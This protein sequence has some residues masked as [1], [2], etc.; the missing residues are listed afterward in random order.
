[1]TSISRLPRNKLNRIK[2]EL[3]LAHEYC[4]FLHDECARLLVEYEAADAERITITFR[5]EAEANRFNE[6]AKKDAIT[7]LRGTG[8][9]AEARRVILNRITMAMTSDLLHH[10]Y[11]AL[12]CLE[13]RKFVV[14]LNL[15][16]KPLMDSL[17]Y[18]SWMLGDEDAFYAAFERGEPEALALKK[19]GNHRAKIIEDAL[20]QTGVAEILDAEYIRRAIFDRKFAEGLHGLFQHAVHLITVDYPELKSSP[21]NF[22]FIFKSHTDE[23]IY[24]GVYE[25]LP[26][27]MLYL[28]HVVLELFDR[29][30][31]ME[32]AGKR[33]FYVRSSTALH[34]IG[35]RAQARD[36]V[37]EL[38][39]PFKNRLH[40]E[41]C[42]SAYRGTIHN[43]ARM[44]MSET[45]RCGCCRRVSPFP[46]SWLFSDEESSD[47]VGEMLT[48]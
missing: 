19:L 1:M 26:P 20:A 42:G 3:R 36:V 46:F 16:R 47:P 24:D 43:A 37:R 38:Y 35:D 23:D 30:R 15:L 32:R 12:R 11:E 6:L 39:L 33:G 18:L 2:P 22:N 4:F 7:A 45:L 25:V 31:P 13:K 29:I 21:E 14:A 28:S 44:L 27:I 9:Q 8:Y 10:I 40:C 5:D 17:T 41:H 34:L 48:I